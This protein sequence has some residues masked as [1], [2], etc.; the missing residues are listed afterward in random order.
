MYNK[1]QTLPL[2]LTICFLQ[3]V[4]KG[5]LFLSC[6]MC[7]NKKLSGNTCMLKK[8]VSTCRDSVLLHCSATY[9]KTVEIAVLP[10]IL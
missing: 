6:V 10:H 9:A 4:M 8:Y 7:A 1:D 3:S 5:Y 2:F